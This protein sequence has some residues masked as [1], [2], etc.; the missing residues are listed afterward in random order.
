MVGSEAAAVAFPTGRILRLPDGG[1][2]VTC[3]CTFGETEKTDR[4]GFLKS[5]DNGASWFLASHIDHAH[6]RF[7]EASLELTLDGRVICVARSRYDEPTPLFQSYSND[8]GS[9]WSELE[10]LDV[11]GVN[12]GLLR[13][14]SGALL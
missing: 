12:P 4:T 7:S 5:T 9:T 1:L 6:Y 10:P 13:L 2:L 3:Q 14:S 8:G 11:C